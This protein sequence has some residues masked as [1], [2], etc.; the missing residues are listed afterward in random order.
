MPRDVQV[1]LSVLVQTESIDDVKVQVV[2]P[3]TKMDFQQQQGR[4]L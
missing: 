2:G 4:E 1:S 3:Q